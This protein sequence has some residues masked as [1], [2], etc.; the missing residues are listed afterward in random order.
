MTPERFHKLHAAL[1]RRQPDLTVLAENVHKPHNLAALARSC[2][3]VGV[4][5][6]HAVTG[7]R[8]LALPRDAAGGSRSWVE[9][10]TH[11]ELHSAAEELKSSGFQIIAAHL[12]YDAKDY[13]AIDYTRP[14]ALL[15]GSELFGVSDQ[16]A[17]LADQ[18]VIIPMRG[19]VASL[20][21]S[22]AAALILFE[23]ARQREAAGLY[24]QS[25]LPEAE[26]QRILFE[27]CHP[28]IAA[29]CRARQLPYPALDEN[30]ELSHHPFAADA[31]AQGTGGPAKG[32]P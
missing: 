6:L 19:L 4:L 16:A 30:G 5:R 14:T 18:T 26:F 24:Q 7:S 1:R 22:V 29:E 12:S 23:A 28:A 27:W 20:N 3:A 2:D 21:V 31:A 10:H 17:A 25:R 32:S 15:L 9:V 8:G 11:S 13:R